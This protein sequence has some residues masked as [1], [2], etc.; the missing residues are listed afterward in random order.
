MGGGTTLAV[1]E[2]LGRRF[3]GIDQ[4]ST[5]VKVTEQRLQNVG[6]HFETIRTETT[7]DRSYRPKAASKKRNKTSKE[8][9]HPI[10]Q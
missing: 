5:A 3:I 1:A 7:D 4:S 8:T 9:L 2:R 6:G 10:L